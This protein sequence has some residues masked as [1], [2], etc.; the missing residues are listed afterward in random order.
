M[1]PEL[2]QHLSEQL[3]L[4]DGDLQGI[5]DKTCT[6]LVMPNIIVTVKVLQSL[7]CGIPIVTPSYWDA[8]ILCAREQ[9]KELPNVNDFVPEISELFIIK[10]PD[11]MQVHLDRQRIFRGK[12]FVFMVKRHMLNF[13]AIIELGGGKCTNLETSRL[14]KASLLKENYIPIAYTPVGNSQCSQDVIG[15]ISYIE[16]NGRRLIAES[17]IGLAIIHRSI[18]RFCNPNHQMINDFRANTLNTNELRVNILVEETPQ[19]QTPAFNSAS[20]V[21][22]A[23]TIDLDGTEPNNNLH[24]ELMMDAEPSTSKGIRKSTT[25]KKPSPAKP[26]METN[27]RKYEDDDTNED[28]V[29]SP[30]APAKKTKHTVAP[31]IHSISSRDLMPPPA[32]PPSQSRFNSSGFI[33]TQNSTRRT[34]QSTQS[35]PSQPQSKEKSAENRKRAI[36]ALIA[37]SDEENDKNDEDLFSFGKKSAKRSKTASKANQSRNKRLINS[38]D[39]DDD[40]PFGFST[41]RASTRSQRSKKNSDELTI[42]EDRPDHAEST[43]IKPY[44]NKE[45]KISS[46]DITSVPSVST[47]WITSKMKNGLNLN[48]KSEQSTSV[49]VKIKEEKIDDDDTENDEKREWVESLANVFRVRTIDVNRSRISLVDETDGASHSVADSTMSTGK[50]FKKFVK[51][52][53][54]VTT[55][56]I[57]QC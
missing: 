31:V 2:A 14:Q 46:L 23:E 43:F 16:N 5:W 6:H 51:V 29:K 53:T 18:E 26:P 41:N 10:E 32:A 42:S 12:T 47:H 52:S 50:N 15:I 25:P 19:C 30:K 39:D 11:M 45:Q 1:K 8:Y 37:D 54:I 3:K 36:S 56:S 34:R 38:D 13:Q 48:A 40:N 33:S 17:E 27:K 55:T 49:Q 44:K 4:I 57:Q 24:S 7:V 21:F 20:S 9:R 22:V 35:E 28:Q